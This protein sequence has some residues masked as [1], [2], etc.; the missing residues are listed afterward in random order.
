MLFRSMKQDPFTLRVALDDAGS[1]HGEL[2]LDDGVSYSH[3]KGQFVWR[4]FKAERQGKAT[5]ISSR[6]L[7]SAHPAEAVDRVA[8]ST[9]DAHNAFAH[10]VESVRVEKLVV[11]GLRGKPSKVKRSDGTSLDWG[12]SEGVASSDSKEGRAS[13][14]VI[15]N[16][17]AR[18]ADD[19]SIVIDA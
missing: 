17:V 14:L 16:P 18:I 12:F 15:K 2:Y 8:L 3:Q 6:D 13:I 7:G 10:S 1:A 11:L 19:W 5:R 9:Y 4:E